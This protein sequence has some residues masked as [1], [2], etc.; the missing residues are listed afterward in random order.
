MAAF[1]VNRKFVSFP[2][3]QTQ[4]LNEASDRDP[5]FLS[6]C[7]C[8]LFYRS[9]TIKHY[10]DVYKSCTSKMFIALY[11]ILQK[12]LFH[13]GKRP[14]P[15]PYLGYYY[16]GLLFRVM[17]KYRKANDSALSASDVLCG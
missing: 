4:I 9:L 12:R 3:N 13:Y 15:L 16:F 11:K 8:F 1:N 10:E 2:D 17:S 5:P 14:S 6:V 7:H